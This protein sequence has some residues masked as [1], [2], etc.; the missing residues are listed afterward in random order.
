MLQVGKDLEKIHITTLKF[1]KYKSGYK[2]RNCDSNV[3]VQIVQTHLPEIK[4]IW[5]S[6]C[7]HGKGNEQL[8]IILRITAIPLKLVR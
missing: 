3:A 2:N 6:T 1:T 5:T 4:T 8:Q 7:Q